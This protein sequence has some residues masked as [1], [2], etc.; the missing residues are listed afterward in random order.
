MQ[1]TCLEVRLEWRTAHELCYPAAC[2][3]QGAYYC[4]CPPRSRLPWIQSL[5]N[6][7]LVYSQERGLHSPHVR[8]EENDDGELELEEIADVGEEVWRR[9]LRAVSYGV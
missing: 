1:L 9:L 5:I 3:A 8:P 6:D 4:A 2:I 7:A